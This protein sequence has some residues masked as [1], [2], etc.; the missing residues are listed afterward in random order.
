MEKL[1]K[2]QKTRDLIFKLKEK[3]E[4]ILEEAKSLIQSFCGGKVNQFLLNKDNTSV[5]L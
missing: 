3:R 4:K 1:I 2:L 5:E